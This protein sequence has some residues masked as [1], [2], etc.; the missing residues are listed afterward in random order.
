MRLAYA[1]RRSRRWLPPAQ[2]WFAWLTVSQLLV[3]AGF[4]CWHQVHH[5][6]GN[7]LTGD[8]AG[9][10]LA[11]GRLAGL[12]AAFACL[13]QVVL[14]SRVKWIES[15]FGLDRLLRWHQVNGCALVSLLLAHPLLVT[16]G[17]ARQADVSAAAQLVDFL[18]AW[19]GALTAAIGLAV[20]LTAIALSLP[21]VR[22]W[23][24]Y[25]VWRTT[26]LAI[27]VALTLAFGHQ[28][29]LGGDL[30]DKPVFRA[31]WMMLYAFVFLN[32][33]VYR[34]LRPL[35][36]FKRHRFYVAALHTEAPDVTSV[37]IRGRGLERLLASGGQFVIV[38]FL[39]RGFRWEAHPFSLSARP[40]GRELRLTI[41]AV[42]DFTQRIPTLPL[43][44]RVILDGPHGVFTARRASAA[45]VVLIA[46]GI[47]ITPVRAML[48]DLLADGR[49]IVLLYASRDREGTVFLAE[50]AQVQAAAGGRLR[51]IP[52]MSA[53]PG[54]TGEK[55]RL[56]GARLARL[57]PELAV[58]DVYL[59]GPPPMMRALRG[60]VLD[61]G[62]PR[63]RL[64]DERF[65]L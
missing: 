32:L 42:G 65:A 10:L 56:D 18:R 49:D 37:T 26:H 19:P 45:R 20:L 35:W 4:W 30:V 1:T 36:F 43:G 9:Q 50:L 12:L 11:W 13:V 33:L 53:D 54:W 25:E 38:R 17:H 14:A 28:L 44:T 46:G 31:Y 7:Q 41:K 40:D 55:G 60:V 64:F 34:V 21:V 6:L 5:P 16:L 51:V 27:Y 39:A 61:A 2:V 29:E 47:G 15:R 3:I 48:E 59:C 23:L 52:V 8:A 22:R 58:S 24:R 57:V 63:N 62:V